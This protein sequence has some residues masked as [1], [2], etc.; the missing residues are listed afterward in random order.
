[1]LD[2]KMLELFC[3]FL[4]VVKGFVCKRRHSL[5]V[6]SAADLQSSGPAFESHSGHYLDLFLGSPEFKCSATLA[7]SQLVCLR[8]VGIPN[9]MFNLN[10]LFQLFAQSH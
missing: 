3:S 6:V 7:N 1:M 5:R 8:R 9:V 4:S 2:L 10:Y